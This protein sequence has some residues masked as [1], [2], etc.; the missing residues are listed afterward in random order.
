MLGLRFDL[1][2]LREQHGHLERL[3]QQRRGRKTR[4]CAHRG[5]E[6]G[7]DLRS[8]RDDERGELR[9]E[10]EVYVECVQLMHAPVLLV[11]ILLADGEELRDVAVLGA[12]VEEVRRETLGGDRVVAR[13]GRAPE[14]RCETD[15]AHE[16]AAHVREF[17]HARRRLLI[18]STA[19][20]ARSSFAA[21]A[22]AAS[23]RARSCRRRRR[24]PE[25]AV[26][27]ARSSGL[28][29]GGEGECGTRCVA[30]SGGAVVPLN[31]E[32]E[33]ESSGVCT[34]DPSVSVLV[35]S[36]MEVWSPSSSS[37]GGGDV[38]VGV[39]G[40]AGVARTRHI[41]YRAARLLHTRQARACFEPSEDVRRQTSTRVER[42]RW[43]RTSEGSF[44]FPYRAG[45][46][47]AGVRGCTS[48]LGGGEGEGGKEGGGEAFGDG[49]REDEVEERGDEGRWE[50]LEGRE[51]W[52]PSDELEVRRLTHAT[53]DI[54]SERWRLCFV[55]F[56][57][58]GSGMATSAF[59]SGR[60][61]SCTPH[62]SCSCSIAD[63]FTSSEHALQRLDARVLPEWPVRGDAV[64]ERA[65]HGHRDEVECDLVQNGSQPGCL[66]ERV[67]RARHLELVQG[68]AM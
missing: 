50:G 63:W 54:R 3:A 36:A 65:R 4:R 19:R 33:G 60:T 29:W 45:G 64:D 67:D 51:P 38:D 10:R 9:G 15:V 61:A 23:M 28:N 34:E 32:L 49:A 31:T 56:A 22:C 40:N 42:A 62:I 1:G 66:V 27:A 58:T 12:H 14:G 17:D 20:N 35:L 48:A 59:G 57:G 21:L 8:G 2:L 30:L 6:R 55:G 43:R 47:G 44:C 25:S 68:Y 7:H 37:D 11:F 39:I 41:R 26:Y 18:S 16:R 13:E 53:S 46:R 24:C 52:W 5:R